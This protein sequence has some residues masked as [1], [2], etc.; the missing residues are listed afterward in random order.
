MSFLD[1]FKGNQ[2]K[3]ELEKLRQEYEHL[4]AF[5]T[6]EMQDA[7]KIKTEIERLQNEQ[8]IEQQK[9]NDLKSTFTARTNEIQ[10]L[11]FLIQ[12]KNK[13]ILYLDEEILV[14]EFGLYKPQYDFASAL[15]YKE[16]LTSIRATQKELIK[17]KEAVTGD[18]QWE[19]NGNKAKG[20]KMVTDTQKL[21]LR[22]FN[23]E[24]DELIAKVR[25]TNFDASL[26]KINKSAEA[27]SKLGTIMN[28]SI[29]QQYL[30][31]KKKELRLAFEYQLKKQQEK[32][33][34]KAARAEQREQAKLQKELEEQR[35]KIEKEQTHYQTAFE[36][37][38]S[39]LELHPDNSDLLDK[40][41]SDR[42]SPFRC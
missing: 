41:K 24:C 13:Q 23:V 6:P 26:N 30:N 17:N 25:Y 7:L 20:K 4:Q 32:E 35:K 1:N 14:Q 9:L 42:K 37:I 36:K 2:Y 31:A 27:I 40:K 33:E 3:A 18:T 5:I 10:N 15:D 28:I 11:E 34:Q 16:A 22:A 21:L 12:Q 29:T 19:V 39:Q 8:A 38:K